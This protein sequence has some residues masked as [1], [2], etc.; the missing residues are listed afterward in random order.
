MGKNDNE[1]TAQ[2]PETVSQIVGQM[3]EV[4]ELKDSFKAEQVLFIKNLI[5]KDLT[6]NELYMFLIFAKRAGLNPFAK[7][8][9]AVV[10]NGQSGR[11]VSTIVTR[12]GKRAVAYRQGGV[13]SIETSP[14]YTKVFKVPTGRVLPLD[15]KDP[16]SAAKVA[17]EPEY[18]DSTVKV[19]PWEGGKLWG[20]TCTVKR[21]GKTHTATVPLS[22]YNT[23]RNVWAKA[24]ETMIKKVAESQALSMAVPEL[25]GTYDEAE[26]PSEAR[27][28]ATGIVEGAD[29]PATVEL[30][31]TIKAM[32]GDDSLTYTKQGAIEEIARL[33]AEK[34]K[35]K[36]E[37]VKE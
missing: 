23:G 10:Y 33:Q 36:K 31:T 26:M 30:I 6:E 29:E 32:G 16:T 15:P 1:T 13:E 28:V 9:I 18:A 7:E 11:V 8:I 4:I 19:E 12:D 14:I 2:M 37:E 20:A 35:A 24:P 5:N 27:Q 22:E 25:L 34:R 3:K 17:N 21:N